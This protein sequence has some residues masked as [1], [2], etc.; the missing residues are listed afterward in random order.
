MGGFSL[1]APE[2]KCLQV[3]SAVLGSLE[4]RAGRCSCWVIG[5]ITR[6]KEDRRY[7]LERACGLEKGLEEKQCTQMQLRRRRCTQWGRSSSDWLISS[8]R[9]MAG[10][11]FS[12][13][14]TAVQRCREVHIRASI[15]GN[16]TSL[17]AAWDRQLNSNLHLGKPRYPSLFVTRLPGE[18]E[19]CFFSWSKPA[20]G[21]QKTCCVR[22]GY[23][24]LLIWSDKNCSL[25]FASSERGE[26][27]IDAR[28]LGSQISKQIWQRCVV[29]SHC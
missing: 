1:Q 8:R 22:N 6:P 19:S 12:H 15:P 27:C 3:P 13:T 18:G 2:G 10:W 29:C 20:L 11:G 26:N 5:P 28:F 9:M 4:L 14:S 16:A 17:F 23:C 25:P 24:V 7:S 21:R